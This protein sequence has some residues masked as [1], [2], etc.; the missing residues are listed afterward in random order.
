M[1]HS[2]GDTNMAKVGVLGFAHGHVFA[3]GGVWKDNPAMH[4][5]IVKGYDHDQQRAKESCEKLGCIYSP[6][7]DDILY[8][9]DIDSVHKVRIAHVEQ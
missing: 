6:T 3:Y 8:D 5:T 4:V 1:T 7:I 9:K 2:K